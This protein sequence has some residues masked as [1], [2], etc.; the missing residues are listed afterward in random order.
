[1]ESWLNFLLVEMQRW[2]FFSGFQGL[3]KSKNN[4]TIHLFASAVE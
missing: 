1:M 3:N 2:M 4:V